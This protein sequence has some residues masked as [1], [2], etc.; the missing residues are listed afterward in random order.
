MTTGNIAAI[1]PY[2]HVPVSDC[3]KHRH[4]LQDDKMILSQDDF[5]TKL[6]GSG[7]NAGT[8][9]GNLS[10]KS[11]DKDE[12]FLPEFAGSKSDPKYQTLPYNTKFTVNFVSTAGTKVGADKQDLDGDTRRN[13][14]A[15]ET[16]KNNNNNL[17]TIN[18][19]NHLNYPSQ[20]QQQQ[21]HLMT[22]HSIPLPTLTEVS[23]GLATPLSQHHGEQSALSAAV[24]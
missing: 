5:H 19:N 12:Q 7:N 6:I 3:E 9:N 23:K 17:N 13:S 15:F 1:E 2:H 16:T 22:V 8:H 11:K 21:Q 14:D 4:H 20:Q 24:G 18:N 10:N